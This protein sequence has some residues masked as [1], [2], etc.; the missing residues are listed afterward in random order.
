SPTDRMT[1]I[2]ATASSILSQNER[3]FPVL[4]EIMA[5][6]SERNFESLLKTI[7]QGASS[8]LDADRATLFLV[9]HY[10]KQIWSKLGQGTGF[11]EIRVPLGAGIAGTVAATGEVINIPEAYEDARFNREIDRKTGYHTKSILCMP[12]KDQDG[13]I[14]GVF[15]VLNKRDGIFTDRD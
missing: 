12:M 11:A 5:A 10:K 1:T 3:L 2:P 14:V 9:D 7:M 15:Q 6:M 13:K 4:M 8:V